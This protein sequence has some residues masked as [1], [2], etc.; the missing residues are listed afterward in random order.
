MKLPIRRTV[1]S[2]RVREK[3]QR[4]GIEPY[5]VNEAISEANSVRRAKYG[6][7]AITGQDESGRRLLVVFYLRRGVAYVATS[8]QVTD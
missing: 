7:Y 3:L 6:A 5:H 2:R 4:R 1:I 8:R